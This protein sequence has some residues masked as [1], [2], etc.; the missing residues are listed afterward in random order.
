MNK[1]VRFEEDDE[2][3]RFILEYIDGFPLHKCIWGYNDGTG[4]PESVARYFAAQI[5]LA[6][7]ALHSQGYMHRDVKSGNVLVSRATGNVT[8]IDFGMAKRIKDRT[9]SLCGTDYIMAP[10]IFSGYSYGFAADWWYA[11]L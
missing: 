2:E 5:V 4:F 11:N 8:L 7:E 10:E 1:S 3:V 6:V 9:S